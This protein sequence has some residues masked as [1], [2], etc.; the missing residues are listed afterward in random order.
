MRAVADDPS[1]AYARA[2][3]IERTRPRDT[4]GKGFAVYEVRQDSIQGRDVGAQPGR[5]L[6]VGRHTSCDLVVSESDPAVSLRHVLVR[7]FSLDDG[8]G[9]LSVLDLDSRS[10][11]ELSNGSKHRAIVASGPIVFRIGATWFVAL[12]VGESLPDELSA[13]LIRHAED[14]SHKVDPRACVGKEQTQQSL[15]RKPLSRITL[16][17]WSEPISQRGIPAGTGGA[18]DAWQVSPPAATP[19][20]IMLEVNGRHASVGLLERDIERG[21]LIG[22]ADKCVDPGLRMILGANL[23][24]SRVHALVIRE[25]DGIVLYDIASMNGTLDDRR[26]RIRRMS[27]TEKAG[28]ETRFYFGGRTTTSV[29]WRVLG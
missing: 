10:G 18:G 11:F 8:P 3:A 15:A 28:E 4:A 5:H 7:A 20:E 27:L 24:A 17:P 25:R 12:P 29:R 13:P 16:V 1:V 2:L 14:G 26:G 21:V 23:N 9:I 22:R 19:F 6:V